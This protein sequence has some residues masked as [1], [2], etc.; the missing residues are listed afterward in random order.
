MILALSHLQ[1]LSGNKVNEINYFSTK[2]KYK[3]GLN[4]AVAFCLLNDFF[5]RKS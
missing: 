4:Y 3:L 1:L 2:K 5:I